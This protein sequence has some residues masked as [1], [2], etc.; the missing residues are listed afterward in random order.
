MLSISVSHNSV[1]GVHLLFISANHYL[2][3]E[4]LQGFGCNKIKSK[5]RLPTKTCI[6]ML[7]ICTA[8]FCNI[9]GWMFI[10]LILGVRLCVYCIA[11]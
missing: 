4:L 10:S 9:S 8:L 1:L 11:F 7:Q 3:V 2:H 5:R 6:I